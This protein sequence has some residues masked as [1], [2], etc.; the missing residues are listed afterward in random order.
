MKVLIIKL[1]ALGDV[2]MSTSLI[3]TIQRHH[4]DDQLVL[5]TSPLF[6]PLFAAW[7]NLRVQTFP[8]LGAML[9]SLRW[10]R[11]EKFQRVYDLQS[12]DRTS[13]LLALSGIAERIGNH[14][15]FPY[16]LHPSDPYRGQCHIFDR[17]N[18]VLAAAGLPEAPPQPHLPAPN[19]TR[20]CVA[21]FL[22]AHQ[23]TDRSFAVLHAGA[24][25]KRGNKRWPYF[26]ELAVAI[27][28]RGIR[29]VWAGAEDDRKINV[30]LSARSGI[31][32]TGAFDILG[33]AE[34]GRHARFAVTNDSGPM[35][36]LSAAGIPVFAL[37][38]P[39]DWRRNHALGQRDRVI[40]S[41]VPCAACQRHAVD[42]HTCLS[43]IAAGKVVGR[44]EHE[45]LLG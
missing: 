13:V 14:P 43:S 37:F 22:A 1:G 9:A 31:D 25:R 44:I 38:G 21:D 34:L 4:R 32:A 10:L 28:D 18:A 27:T 45:H 41:D 36:V 20:R 12:N 40:V 24:S 5:M 7:P 42:G 23:L 33:L 30:E 6:A 17:M 8:R 3:H 35:H 11:R 29:C 39:S 26:A 15:R 2:I 16:H 19:D